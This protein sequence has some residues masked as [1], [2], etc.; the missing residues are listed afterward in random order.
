MTFFASLHRFSDV[1]LLLLRLALG[2]VF[3]VH[4]L[5]KRHLWKAQPSPQMP[6]GMLR[7]LRILSIAEP[8][9]ALGLIFG[10]LTQLAALGLCVSMLGALQFLI[11]K[12]HRKFKEA[13]A[14]GWEFEFMLLVIAISLAILG[15]GKYALDRLV[16]GI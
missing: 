5:P 11:T 1:A 9:G 3:L 4:G 6:A 8:A 15:G 2:T 13:Q 14:P 7:N 12:V 10:F 16:F